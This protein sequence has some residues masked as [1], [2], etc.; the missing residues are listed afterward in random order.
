MK[1]KLIIIAIIMLMMLPMQTVTAKEKEEEYG[2]AEAYIKFLNGDWIDPGVEDISLDTYEP[3]WVKLKIT[4]KEK[5][6]VDFSIT[7]P[8]HGDN[9]D[10]VEGPTECTSMTMITDLGH[11]MNC[12]PG[13]NGT[14]EWKIHPN[15]NWAGGTAGLNLDVFFSTREKTE[16]IVF[17]LLYTYINKTIWAGYTEEEKNPDGNQ[18]GNN[19]QKNDTAGFETITLMIA[20]MLVCFILKKTR[21]SNK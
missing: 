12:E 15:D 19:D 8:G 10:T 9:F 18:D 11:Y 16:N 14:W 3:F 21:K 2:K 13:W 4:V 5:C 6:H 7:G 17:P 1:N 20:L